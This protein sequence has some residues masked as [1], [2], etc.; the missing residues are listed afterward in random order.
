MNHTHTH[1]PIPFPRKS[2][3]AQSGPTRGDGPRD[4]VSLLR[5]VGG[6]RVVPSPPTAER[7]AA[8]RGYAADVSDLDDALDAYRSSRAL[9]CGLSLGEVHL[10]DDPAAV[11][12]FLDRFFSQPASNKAGHGSGGASPQGAASPSRP[13]TEQWVNS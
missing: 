4:V 3:N 11:Q 9:D 8:S 1:G 5:C 13:G 2:D 6:V 7:P 12:A 10:T